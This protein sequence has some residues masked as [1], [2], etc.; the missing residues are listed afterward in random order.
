[1]SEQN[2]KLLN[3]TI[4]GNNYQVESGTSVLN[5]CKKNGIKI[6]H[7]CYHPSL[8]IAGN[9]R[10]C[11]VKIEKIPKLAIACATPINDGMVIDTESAEV[12][13]A[14]DSVME[15]LLINH[16][17]D[18]PVCDQAGECKLQ[19][20]SYKY[21]KSVGRF[22]E[23]KVVKHTK[24]LGSHVK[25]WGTR[26]IL[27]TRCV[28][29]AREISGT[30]ELAV[31]NRGDH[32]EIGI[33]PGNELNNPLSMNVVDICPVGALVSTEFLYQARVWFLQQKESICLECSV[34]CNTRIDSLNNTIK[35]IVP[36]RNAYVNQSFMCD[37][38]R[39]SFDYIYSDSR[40]KSPR[41]EGEN[42]TWREGIDLF[43]K[44]I[45]EYKDN[46]S[47]NVAFLVSAWA[48]NEL[49]FLIK[50]LKEEYLKDSNIFFFAREHVND[51][52]FPKFRISGDRN[53]N[54]NGIKT[55]FNA[56]SLEDKS[57]TALIEDINKNE[58]STLIYVGG[59]PGNYF[60]KELSESINKLSYIIAIDYS[61][62]DVNKKAKLILPSLSYAEKS[63]TYINDQN[64]IQRMLPAI[65]SIGGGKSEDVILQELLIA[66][67]G[68]GKL[69]DS[70]AVFDM[71]HEI[72]DFKNLNY[73]S[74]SNSGTLLKPLEE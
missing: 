26:C 9:C 41:V 57:L 30:N 71:M 29:F 49:L 60:P 6:P 15:F 38:G 50:R 72:S 35:R 16:P 44:K 43:S 66:L 31:F 33:F 23:E 58:I 47:K 18:C 11:L 19:D 27:C 37:E 42:V 73:Q 62:N 56:K 46:K 20:Y 1:M 70:S 40:I 67:K 4:N 8:S 54:V 51:Q 68:E 53:P 52:I 63:G 64:R 61:Q 13:K 22:K 55:I 48:S 24:D 28:R 17:L 39:L 7:Y 74:I 10:M 21:G 5:A 36:R 3:I 14:R 69:V 45:K 12:V 65:D 59:I 32:A 34:G 25:Y 2:S